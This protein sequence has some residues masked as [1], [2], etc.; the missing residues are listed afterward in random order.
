VLGAL[1][2]AGGL[3][4]F[5]DGD[6]VYVLRE[7]PKRTRIRFKYDDLARGEDKAVGFKLR[8]RDVVIVE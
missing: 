2:R 3:T 1:A 7:F 6:S 5:A 4:E 8:D